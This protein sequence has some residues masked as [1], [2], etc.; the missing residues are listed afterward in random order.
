MVH[1]I[2]CLTINKDF[3]LTPR[4]LNPYLFDLSV[5]DDSGSFKKANLSFLL[6]S[7]DPMVYKNILISKSDKK[8]KVQD[9]G[10]F[11]IK[12]KQIETQIYIDVTSS[13]NFKKIDED[14]DGLEEYNVKEKDKP[15]VLEVKNDLKIDRSKDCTFYFNQD[16]PIDI[17]AFSLMSSENL[18]IAYHAKAENLDIYI[19]Q[20]SDT[21]FNIHNNVETLRF[22]AF[23]E[24]NDEHPDRIKGV[25]HIKSD[26]DRAKAIK[27]I[28]CRATYLASN[29]PSKK[30]DLTLT[31]N[32]YIDIYSSRILGGYGKREISGNTDDIKIY[33]ADL[34]LEADLKLNV[35]KFRV[36]FEDGA[37]DYPPVF[38]V[39]EKSSITC[40]TFSSKNQTV[41]LKN[42]HLNAP[43]GDIQFY[44]YWKHRKPDVYYISL[45]DFVFNDLS[46]NG[47]CLSSFSSQGGS[48]LVDKNMPKEF[49]PPIFTGTADGT[50][51]SNFAING[52]DDGKKKVRFNIFQDSKAPNGYRHFNNVTFSNNAHISITSP[53]SDK[54]S[55][56][57]ENC[58]FSGDEY[59]FDIKSGDLTALNS[60]FKNSNMVIDGQITKSGRISQIAVNNSIIEDRATLKNI[61]NIKIDSST[62]KDSTLDGAE[63]VSDY[64]LEN[65]YS[66]ANKL[67]NITSEGIISNQKDPGI[68]TEG[69]ELL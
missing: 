62:I 13:V 21:T 65:V 43:D 8:G 40:D 58:I 31:A 38:K 1:S 30:V 11:I 64:C 9:F 37:I 16:E 60:E 27:S 28:S 54:S 48:I 6:N 14:Y 32:K 61:N 66:R 33:G 45:K 44:N 22:F 63:E 10:G 29:D 53:L 52:D 42:T 19:K 3:K 4:L 20:S 23:N 59:S 35:N 67:A 69:V 12:P 56:N 25:L 47:L 41:L 5:K 18:S 24:K 17:D 49:L 15:L 50:T 55:T 7:F 39:E 34:E 46:G 36:L 2:N 51:I 26:K 57:F 68:A